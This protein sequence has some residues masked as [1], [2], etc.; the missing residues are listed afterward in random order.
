MAEFSTLAPPTKDNEKVEMDTL[1]RVNTHSSKVDLPVEKGIED[2]ESRYLTGKRLVLVH[3]GVL[4]AVLLVSLPKLSSQFNALDQLT[5]IVSAYFCKCAASPNSS[6]NSRSVT[7]AGL[8][9]TFGQILTIAPSKYVFLFAISVFEIGSLLCGVAPTIEVLIFGRAVEGVG[10]SGGFIAVLT[11][12]SQVAKLETRPILLGSF[13][14]VF[15][16]ASV[17]GPLVG[18]VF[19]DKLTWRWCFYVSGFN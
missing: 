7:Q 12:I 19:T 2:A 18:G 9:L 10:S 6:S 11:I 17:I 1:T 13:G 5:W 15:G 16:F 14:A 3:T 8:M 4:L